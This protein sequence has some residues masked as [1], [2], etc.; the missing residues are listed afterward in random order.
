MGRIYIITDGQ[1]TLCIRK[2]SMEGLTYP[3]LFFEVNGRMW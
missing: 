3:K 2:F 1:S